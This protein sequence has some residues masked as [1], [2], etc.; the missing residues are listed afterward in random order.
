[1]AEE[2]GARTHVSLMAQ[3]YPACR[4]RE[5]HELARRITLEEWTRAVRVIESAGLENGW[6][7][8][9]QE[10]VSTIAGTEIDADRAA[11]V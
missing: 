8:E 3:Y 7:Q 11:S 10:D 9:Y 6:V 5:F 1:M 2:L 4:A